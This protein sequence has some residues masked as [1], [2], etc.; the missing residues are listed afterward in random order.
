MADL[1]KNFIFHGSILAMAG[2]LVRII[3]MIY[4]IPMV[5]IIGSEGNGIYSVAFNVYNVMLILS[6]YG[7]PMAV[8]KLVAAR[9]AKKEYANAKMIFT[10][11]LMF[12]F[13]TGGAAGLLI[14]LGA[15]FLEATIYTGY[16]GIAMPLKV[17]APTIFI[18]AILGVLRGFFQGMGSMIPTAISQIIEQIVN[19]IVSIVAAAIL[20]KGF[21]DSNLVA[22]YGAAGGTLGTAMGAFAAMV[23]VGILVLRHMPRYNKIIDE[24]NSTVTLERAEVFKLIAITVAPIILSQTLYQISAMIDDI[25][26]GNIMTQLGMSATQIKT[27]IGNFGS[28]YNILISIPM[29]VASA[30]SASMLP[31][32]VRSHAVG[33]NEAINSKIASTIQ[34][35]ML[36]VI[37]SFVGLFVL[38][39]P[40]VQLLFSRYDSYVGGMMLKIGGIS[41][42]FYTLSTVTSSALQGIDKMRVPVKHA[43]ISLGVHVV[44]TFVLLRFTDL[45][46]YGVVIGNAT[47]P[48]LIF[49]LNFFSLKKYVGYKQEG[50]KTFGVLGAIAIVMGICCRLTYDLLYKATGR[51][52]VAV[53]LA[54]VVAVIVYFGIVFVYRRT[55]YRKKGKR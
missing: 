12:G 24:N 17:L 25:M 15:D 27:D 22:G 20:V 35:N 31:S 38:G 52:L 45:G 29:G 18:V 28:S 19:A 11:A 1:K 26:F 47:F 54:V 50:L 32:V 49:I 23:F 4:R 55:V 34:A 51:G 46:I 40:I 13:I 9:T 39:E 6:S 21:A 2:I 16:E 7:L 36:I 5:N 33:N 41:T 53:A 10:S 3:G 37:P 42:V 14:F 8:S 30:M 44:I 43:G 48:V